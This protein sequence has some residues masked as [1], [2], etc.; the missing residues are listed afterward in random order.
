MAKFGYH[1]EECEQTVWPAAPRPELAWLKDRQHILREVARHVQAGLDTW[2][3]QGLDF[4][5]N[6]TGHS[7]T[8]SRRGE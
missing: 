8:I 3:T 2:M 6:H 5:D 1:C 7:V 4:L